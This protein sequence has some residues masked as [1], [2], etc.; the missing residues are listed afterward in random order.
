MNMKSI[1]ALSAGILTLLFF[2]CSVEQPE[3]ETTLQEIVVILDIDTAFDNVNS[4]ET[5]LIGD[6]QIT[7]SDLITEET[8]VTEIIKS[9]SCDDVVSQVL[10]IDTEPIISSHGSPKTKQIIASVTDIKPAPEPIYVPS[11]EPTPKPVPTPIPQPTPEPPPTSEHPPSPP[12]LNV[13]PPP[14]RTICNICEADITGNV[15]AHGTIY[16][17]NEENFSYRVE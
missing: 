6:S 12:L 9:E 15:A 16:L 14:A 2:G 13:E 7:D 4:E 10:I 17:L 11:Q 8:V 5:L 1:I 3:N